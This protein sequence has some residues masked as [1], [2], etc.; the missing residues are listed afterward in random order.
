M[1]LLK[2]PKNV[3][4]TAQ[5]QPWSDEELT[6]FRKLMTEIKAKNTKAKVQPYPK[7]RKV[8]A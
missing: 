2:E 3:D 4:F 1:G 5:S 8:G 6:E 7:K